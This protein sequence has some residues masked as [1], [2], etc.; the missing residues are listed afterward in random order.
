N[1][2]KPTTAISQGK[3]GWWRSLIRVKS[4]SVATAR[5]EIAALIHLSPNTHVVV[6]PYDSIQRHICR[7]TTVCNDIDRVSR[8]LNDR[9]CT[10]SVVHGDVGLTVTIIIPLDRRPCRPS[11]A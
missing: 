5:S 11:M 2:H 1:P 7:A 8:G 3:F 10:N 9:P 4:C 6:F